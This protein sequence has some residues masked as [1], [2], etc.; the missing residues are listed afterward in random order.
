[1]IAS[2]ICLLMFTCIIGTPAMIKDNDQ[3]IDGSSSLVVL[4]FFCVYCT[5]S[6]FS[7]INR[8]TK[9]VEIE[10]KSKLQYVATAIGTLGIAV[11]FG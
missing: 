1:M 11:I 10:R 3:I 5:L 2:I 9:K 7:C 8:K 6:I 4:I